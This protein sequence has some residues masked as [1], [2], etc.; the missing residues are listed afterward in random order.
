MFFPELLL[1]GLPALIASGMSYLGRN[2]NRDLQ[3]KRLEQERDLQ[4]LRLRFQAAQEQERQLHQSVEAERNR[5]AQLENN[6]AQHVFTGQENAYNRASTRANLLTQ[7][8]AQRALQLEIK[9]L[10]AEL[11]RELKR[12]DRETALNQMKEQRRNQNNP[13]VNHVEDLLTGEMLHV[14]F[15]PPTVRGD[16][17]AVEQTLKVSETLLASALRDFLE[18]FKKANRAV[19]FHGGQWQTRAVHSETAARN[20]H[21]EL[22]SEATII[23]ET[24]SEGNFYHIHV[25]FWAENWADVRY[26]RIFSF[27]WTEVLKLFAKVNTLKRQ[28]EALADEDFI[29]FYGKPAFDTYKRNLDTIGKEE[30]ARRARLSEKDIKRNISSKYIPNQDDQESVIEYIKLHHAF[31]IGALMDEYYLLH[32]ALEQRRPPLLPQLLPHLL[33]DYELPAAQKETLLTQ[34]AD[35]YTQLYDLVRQNGETWLPEQ[36]LKLAD[37]YLQLER[38]DKARQALEQSARALLEKRCIPTLPEAD[39]ACIAFLTH[40]VA[41]PY[42]SMADAAFLEGLA[43]RMRKV[44]LL[45]NEADAL[46]QVKDLETGVGSCG[47]QALGDCYRDGRGVACNLEKAFENYLKSAELGDHWGYFGMGLFLQEGSRNIPQDLD[48]AEKMFESAK[49]RGNTQAQLKLDELKQ[50]KYAAEKRKEAESEE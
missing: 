28:Q 36:Y 4:D 9:Q 37:L 8:D 39:T 3:L 33:E 1:K 14:F 18:S 34:L 2:E 50:A 40:E 35:F 29:D 11:A 22:K 32:A 24:F 5:I 46:F 44:P 26:Q 41:L 6:Q 23:L 43:N 17:N 7:L 12:F 13:L 10:D 15:A 38:Y 30:R 19:V 16:K 47:Y 31:A 48:K 45:S 20:I 49:K 21:R 42:L 25:A 27:D